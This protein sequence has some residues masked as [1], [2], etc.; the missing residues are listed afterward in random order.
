[1][2]G[3]LCVLDVAVCLAVLLVLLVL[4]VLVLG[5]VGR[6]SVRGRDHPVAFPDRRQ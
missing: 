4:L 2:Q 1:M 5:A 6:G 3:A